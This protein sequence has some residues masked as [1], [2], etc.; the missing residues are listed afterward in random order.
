MASADC[1]YGLG[2]LYI[3]A[4]LDEADLLGVVREGDVRAV[5]ALAR[6][7]LLLQLDHLRITSGPSREHHMTMA[8]ESRDEDMS[9]CDQRV[10][11]V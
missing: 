8:W 1:T 10:T 9:M 2:G 7:V 5:D 3:W 6:V 4:L 11:S